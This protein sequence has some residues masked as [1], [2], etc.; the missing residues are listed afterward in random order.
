VAVI[1]LQIMNIIKT[2][3]VS[4]V[5]LHALELFSTL[6]YLLSAP[7]GVV[8]RVESLWGRMGESTRQVDGLFESLLAES[9]G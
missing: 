2:S 4:F 3:I 9:F 8:T 1:K 7:A 6:K 5:L